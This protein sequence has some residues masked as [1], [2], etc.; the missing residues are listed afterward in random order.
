MLLIFLTSFAQ[1]H[2]SL[3]SSRDYFRNIHLQMKFPGGFKLR[4]LLQGVSKVI[5]HY[6]TEIHYD[7]NCIF[8]GNNAYIYWRKIYL[9]NY[10]DSFYFKC[11]GLSLYDVT[12]VRH[13]NI[14][15]WHL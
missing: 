3:A 6:V 11:G 12:I 15:T 13:G 10:K 8:T 4:V 9:Y 7:D 14:N 1:K 5:Y 2:G